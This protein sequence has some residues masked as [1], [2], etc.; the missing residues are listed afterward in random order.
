MEWEG[1][2]RVE[3]DC[4]LLSRMEKCVIKT[5]SDD[6]DDRTEETCAMVGRKQGIAQ[7]VYWYI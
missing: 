1:E 2:G 6:C 4:S 7:L 3:G 5:P